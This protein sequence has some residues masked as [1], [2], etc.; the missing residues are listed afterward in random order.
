MPPCKRSAEATVHATVHGETT[1]LRWSIEICLGSPTWQ[2]RDRLLAA[3]LAAGV[4]VR[5]DSGLRALRQNEGAG[6]GS[7]SG[8]ATHTGTGS[9]GRAAGPPP[10][11]SSGSG[12]SGS[13]GGRDREQHGAAAPSGGGD[14]GGGGGCSSWSC[15]L[16]GGGSVS[17]GVVVRPAPLF[18]SVAH[19][20]RH[21][22]PP[23]H[24][25]YHLWPWSFKA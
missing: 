9:E 17:C 16:L 25:V 18:G 13:G 4:T 6:P 10:A 7:S 23:I 8:G 20:R 21:A 22:V 11:R 2:V 1:L 5:Y 12:G 19:R 14:A 3:C 15:D 24:H